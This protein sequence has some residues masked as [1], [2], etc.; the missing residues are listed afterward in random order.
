MQEPTLVLNRNWQAIGTATLRHAFVLVVRGAAR[1]IDPSTYEV[2][3]LER[4][5]ERSD[6]RAAE[7]PRERLVKTPNHLVE[8]PEVVLLTHYGKFPRIEV[9]FSRKNLYRRDD[10]SCQYCG[11]RAGK[12]QMSIDHVVPRSRGGRTTWEN[13]VLACVRCNSRKADRLP[14]DVGLRLLKAPARP[15]WSPLVDLLPQSRPESWDH[16]LKGVG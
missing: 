12:I 8:K 15:R 3:S 7:L 6:E 5:L 13:C 11:R 4:W 1:P 10:H 14:A 2:Y 9:S 16:F